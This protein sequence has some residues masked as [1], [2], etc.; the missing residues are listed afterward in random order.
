MQLLE[1]DWYR[2][3]E[4]MI[5]NPS[6]QEVYPGCW[7]IITNPNTFSSPCFLYLSKLVP[8]CLRRGGLCQEVFF[9]MSW[10]RLTGT[11]STC[12]IV[13]LSSGMTPWAKSAIPSKSYF[14][15]S[16]LQA[17]QPRLGFSSE[18]SALKCLSFCRAPFTGGVC[19]NGPAG[20]CREPLK[21]SPKKQPG[22]RG[23]DAILWC[24][25]SQLLCSFGSG[26]F[27]VCVPLASDAQQGAARGG[28]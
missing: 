3:A 20:A 1:W 8:S 23:K 14:S 25:C 13:P 21:N 11:N 9:E 2:R 5:C 4:P 28:F 18:I 6:E 16:F 17:N 7:C 24:L 19:V 27:R 10:P 26:K 12:A 15:T 22:A